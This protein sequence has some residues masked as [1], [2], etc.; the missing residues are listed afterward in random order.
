MDDEGKPLW[1]VLL[2]VDDI[3]KALLEC[4]KK[5]FHQAAAT[6]FGNEVGGGILADL[7]GYSG[8][9]T[10]A[11]A[12]VEGTLME[13]YGDSVD[14]L[15]EMTSLIMELMMPEEIQQLGRINPEVSSED[16]FSWLS[17]LEGVHFHVFFGLAS[18]TL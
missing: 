9:T 7:V 18:W 8:L 3:H 15:P 5:H 4:N 1:E 16:F 12:I 13:Q 14:M 6:S 10:V 2:K 11:K 17:K